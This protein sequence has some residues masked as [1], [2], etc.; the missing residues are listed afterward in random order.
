MQLLQYDHCGTRVLLIVTNET[1][2][3]ERTRF[4][5]T[6]ATNEDRHIHLDLVRNTDTCNAYILFVYFTT[7]LIYVF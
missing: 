6:F 7:I 1:K 5:P 2:E 4:L 3:Q